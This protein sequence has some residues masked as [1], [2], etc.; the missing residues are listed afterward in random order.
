[1][2]MAIS[3]YKNNKIKLKLKAAE[4]FR[5]PKS[6]LYEQLSGVKPYIETR[7]NSYRIIV[8]KLKRKLLLSIS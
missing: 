8:I 1:M 5:V 7:A 6:T 2:Q 4:V 3:T